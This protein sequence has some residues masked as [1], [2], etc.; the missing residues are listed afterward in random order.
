MRRGI[1]VYL[2]LLRIRYKN[3]RHGDTGMAFYGAEWFCLIIVWRKGFGLGV[4]SPGRHG[5]H[6]IRIYVH[7]L[8]GRRRRYPLFSSHTEIL[9]PISDQMHASLSETALV[10]SL[11]S[12]SAAFRG[13]IMFYFLTTRDETGFS[14]ESRN[15]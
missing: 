7:P 8:R 5:L 12:T 11:P 14:P 2:N 1:I 6:G 13:T 9:F 3:R 10:Y 15:S 4:F